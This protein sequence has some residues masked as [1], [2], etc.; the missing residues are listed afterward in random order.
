MSDSVLCMASKMQTRRDDGEM[1]RK[2]AFQVI[3]LVSFILSGAK[4]FLAFVKPLFRHV[5]GFTRLG[6]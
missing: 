3:V 1:E 5:A 2:A 6:L 4:L